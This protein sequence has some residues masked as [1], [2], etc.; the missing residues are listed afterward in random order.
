VPPDITAPATEPEKVWEEFCQ[1][2]RINHNGT[3]V[4]PAPQLG[5]IL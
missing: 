4:P 2:A 5:L 1:E 3:M